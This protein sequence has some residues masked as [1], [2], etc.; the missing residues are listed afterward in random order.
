MSAF[1]VG[2]TTPTKDA[3]T[4]VMSTPDKDSGP[5]SRFVKW[6]PGDAITVYTAILALETSSGDETVAVAGPVAEAEPEVGGGLGG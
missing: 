1:S 4:K 6:I 3:A 2:T 5:G